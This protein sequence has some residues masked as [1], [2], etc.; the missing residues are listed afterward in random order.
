MKKNDERVRED[1]VN[2]YLD[3]MEQLQGPVMEQE[4]MNYAEMNEV[5]RLNC[6]QEEE[7]GEYSMIDRWVQLY[8]GLMDL[9]HGIFKQ[10]SPDIEAI[11]QEW[12]RCFQPAAVPVSEQLTAKWV[13]TYLDFVEQYQGRLEPEKA[14]A[15][16]EINRE[17]IRCF[18]PQVA[19]QEG[20]LIEKWEAIFLQLSNELRG[21]TETKPAL[22]IEEINDEWCR[23]FLQGEVMTLS[24]KKKVA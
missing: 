6:M 12:I 24:L 8:L 14:V 16:E 4:A 10:P 9:L 13:N 22:S 17:W 21:I 23:L 3:I 1:W 2:S 7:V 15:I 18:L 19:E 20:Q 5:L 11:N